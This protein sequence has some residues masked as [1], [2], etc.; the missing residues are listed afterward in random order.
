MVEPLSS[1]GFIRNN[2]RTYY[3]AKSNNYNIV[4]I[5]FIRDTK[6][7]KNVGKELGSKYR[8]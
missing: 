4:S 7:K 6:K 3:T 8:K 1:S 5:Y 2:F